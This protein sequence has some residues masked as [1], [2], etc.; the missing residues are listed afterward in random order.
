MKSIDIKKL[1]LVLFSSFVTFSLFAKEVVFVRSGSSGD[2]S[3]WNKALGS[4]Q[5]AVD[6]ASQKNADV[7][8]AKGVYKNDSVAVVS[9]KP[10]VNLYGGFAGNESSI[11][12]RDTAKNPTVL[13]GDQKMRVIFQEN[14]FAD[15]MAVIVDGFIIQNGTATDGGGA[16]LRK[17]AVVNNCIL[18]GNMASNRGSAIYAT[19]ATIKNS[20]IVGNTYLTNLSYTIQLY[21]CEMEG[22][23]VKNNMGYYHSAICAENNS[24]VSNCE[25]EN[26]QSYSGYKGSYFGS[27][28]VSNCRFIN[29]DGNGSSVD[30]RGST[31]M[32]SCLFKGNKNIGS[33]L[34]YVPDSN[35]L[36]EDCQIIDNS[37]ISTLSVLS[38]KFNRCILKGNTTSSRI[39][40]SQ[41]FSTCISNC[42][43]CNNVCTSSYEP[44]YCNNNVTISNC[45][46]VCNESNNAYF[47][48]LSGSTLKNSIVVGNKMNSQINNILNLRGSNTVVN[49]MLESTSIDGNLCGSMNYAAFTDVESGDFSLSANSYCINAGAEV[50]DTIDLLGKARI[51]GGVVDMG[52]IESSHTKTVAFK[53]GDIVYVKSG[54]NGDG[55]SWKSAFGDVQQAVFAASTDGKKHQI[56]V[57]AGT[58]Y[59]DTTLSSVVFLSD[60]ISMYGGFAGNET[61]LAAR[62][63]VKNPTVLDG[64]NKRRVITQSCDFADSTAIV[65]DGFI[66]QNGNAEYGGGAYL[67]KNAAVNNCILRNNTATYCGLAIYAYCAKIKNSI[68]CNNNSSEAH[69]TVHLNN[70]EMDSCVVKNNTALYTSAINADLSTVSNS[71]ID[72]NKN[73]YKSGGSPLYLNDQS[74][75]TNCIITN[76]YGRNGGVYAYNRCL[77]KNC[78]FSNNISTA[79]SVIHIESNSRI[80]DSKIFDNE[81]INYE[82]VYIYNN[83]S[84]NRC[85]VYNNVV[86]NNHN[87]VNILYSS[88]LYNSLIYGNENKKASYVPLRVAFNSKMINTTFADNVTGAQFALSL[89][90][91]TI[92]NSIVVGNRFVNS[93]KNYIE[94]NG[95]NSISYSMI[96]GGAV[97]EGNISGSKSMASF[98]DPENGDYSLSEKSYCIDRGIETNDSL[99]LLG[100]HRKLNGAVDL[101]AIESQY[102]KATTQSVGEIIYVKEGATGDGS[103]WKSAFGDVSEAIKVAELDGKKHQIWVASGTYYGDT[104]MSTVVRLTRDISLYGGFVG[105]ET[106][107]AARDTAKNPTVLDGMNKRRVITQNYDF[108]DS[109][110]IVV[111][112]FIIQNGYAENGGG[113]YVLKNTTVNNCIIKNC[114]AN[115]YGMAVYSNGAKVANSLICANGSMD[116]P[117]YDKNATLYLIGGLIDSCIVKDN[118]SYSIGVL[119][120]ESSIVTNSL[121]EGNE[122]ATSDVM[123]FSA[124]ILSDCKIINN[125]NSKYNDYFIFGR[126]YSK[127]DRC[128]ID[129][130]KSYGS[131]IFINGNSVLSNSQITNCKSIESNLIYINGNSKMLNC[132]VVDNESRYETIY[133]YSDTQILNSIIVGNKHTYAN[134]NIQ[135]N[136]GGVIKYCMIEGGAN[137]ERNIDGNKSSASFVDV[138]NGDYSLSKSSICIN[139]GTDISDTLD[140]LGNARKQN[141]AVD[142]GAIESSFSRKISIDSIIYVKAGANGS[143]LSWDDA[144]GEINQAIT[145][146]TTTGKR[147]KIWVAKGTYYGDTTS[148][149]A[150]SLA[151]GIDLYGGFEGSESSLDERNIAKNTTIIDGLAKRKCVTQNYDFADSLAIVVNGFTIQN[152]YT[153]DYSDG[154]NAKSLKN[155]SFINCVFRESKKSDKCVHAEKSKFISCTFIDNYNCD[156]YISNGE[157]DSCTF[158]K[159]HSG[160]GS[161][162]VELT[163]SRMTNS[164]IYDNDPEYGCLDVSSN[165]VVSNCRISN[166]KNV[167]SSTINMNNSVI[168]NSLIYDNV[169]NSSSV[170]YSYHNSYIT[171]STIAN[172]TTQNRSTVDLYNNSGSE[173]F[174]ITNTIIYGNKMTNEVK[175]QVAKSD[176]LKVMYCA[177]DDDLNGENNIKLAR[178]NNGSD[179]TLNYVCFIN[180]VGGDYR[181]HSTSSCIDKGLDSVM[182]LKTDI[183]GRTRIYGKAIDL[184]AIE[185]NGGSD[186]M[187]DYHQVVCY[188]KNTFEVKFDTT[189]STL[190]WNITNKGQVEGFDSTS[191]N[192]SCIPTMRLR[193]SKNIIDTLTLKVT[194]YDKDS[195]GGMPFSYN[196]YVYPDFSKNKVTFIQPNESYVVNKKSN[197]MTIQWKK[198][199]LPVE[200]SNYDLYVWKSTQEMPSTPMNSFVNTNSK[201]LSGLDNHTTYKYM[202]K[203]ATACDTVCSEIDSFRIDIPIG[204]EI[205][206]NVYCEFGSKLNE[207]SSLIRYV[208]GV[209]LTD[210]ITYVISGKDSADFSANFEQDWD[211]YNGGHLRIY[212]S[213]VDANKKNSDAK[214]TLKSGKYEA[215]L[216]L[217]GILSNYYVFDAVVD[218]DVY[219]AGDT[220]AIKGFVSD[221]YG[222]PMSGKALK[223]SLKKGGIE[224]KTFEEMSASN[225]VVNVNYISS[226]YE[227]GVYSVGLC[228]NSEKSDIVYDEFDIPG[229]SCSIGTDKWIVQKGDTVYGTVTVRNRSNVE[230]H[231]VKVRTLTLA[232]GCKVVFDSIDVLH[233]LESRELNYYVVGESLTNGD[234]L[235]LSSFRVQTAESLIAGFSTY[236]YCENPY[237]LIKVLPANIK[238][239][240]SK[241]KPKFVELLLCNTGLGETGKVSV[242][243]PKEFE[244]MTMLGGTEIES[245]KSGDTTKAILKLAYYDGAKLNTPITGSIGINCENGKSTTIGFS[246]EYTSSLVGSVSV[247]VVD[248]YYYNTTAKSHLS[249]ATVEI[250]NAFDSKVIASGISDSLGKVHFDSIPEGEYL[251]CIKADKHSNYREPISVQAGQNLNKFIFVS[252]QAVTYTWN[253]ERT[254]IEDK[255]EM[256]LNAEFET[257]VPAPVVT[258]EF[259]NGF[260]ERESF[261]PGDKKIAHLV[262][263]NHGLIAAKNVKINAPKTNGYIFIPDIDH[264]DSLPANYSVVVPV[265]IER[266]NTDGSF[267]LTR[268]FSGG[269]FSNGNSITDGNFVQGCLYWNIHYVYE[270]N[271]EE[272]KN[273]YVQVWRC[274]SDD[275]I[276]NIGDGGDGE[277]HVGNYGLV[278]RNCNDTCQVKIDGLW[279]CLFDLVG[280]IPA[281]GD[282]LEGTYVVSKGRKIGSVGNLIDY[283]R[284]YYGAS[285]ELFSTVDDAS[286]GISKRELNSH[287][288]S[289][290]TIGFGLIPVVGDIPFGCFDLLCQ[291]FSCWVNGKYAKNCAEYFYDRDSI[292]NAINGSL[293]S[294]TESV[295]F[296]KYASPYL[297]AVHDLLELT[298]FEVSRSRLIAEYV[299][300]D[301]VMMKK[302]GLKDYLDVFMD[303]IAFRK[304]ID[305]EKVKTL[306]ASD[307]SLTEM[308]EISER[309]NRTVDAW[310]DSVFVSDEKYP[311]IVD[312]SIVDNHLDII[313]NFYQYV[314]FRGFDDI[315]DMVDFINAEMS[316]KNKQRKSVCASVKLQISQTMTMTREAFDGTLT[317]NN[318][319]ESLDMD[320]FRVILEVRDENGNLANDLFQINT[321]SLKGID[322]VD[323]T[324]SIG[325]GNEA[326]AVFR[327]I[328]ERG[329]APTTPVNY[330]FGGK[331]IYLEAGDTITIDM[332]PVTLTVNPSPNLQI[333]YFMQRNILGD[334]ALT[335]DR[336]EPTVPAALGVRIDNHGYGIA[337][338]VK[339]ETAQPEIVENEKGLLID[340]SIIGSSLDGKNYDL[341]SENIDFGNIEAHTAKTGVWW[342]T[343]SLLGHFTKYEA[344][345]VHANSFGNPEL[346]LVSGIA[347]HELIKTVD[348]YGVKEDHVTDFLVNDYEDGDD[349]PDAIYYS[350][351]GKDTVSVAKNTKL[352]KTIVTAADTV[353]KLTVSPSENGWNYAQMNDPG[354]NC[355]DIKRV[356]RVKDNVEIPLS[357][358][359]T[360]FVTLP[361]GEEPIYENRLHFLDYMTTLSETD[362]N[363]YFSQKK[364]LLMVTEIA[365]APSNEETVTSSIDSVIVKFN[366]KI[367]KNSFDYNDIELYCQA[368]NNLSDSTITVK[369]RDDYTYVVNISSKT[370]TS[371]FYKFEVN[372]DNVYDEL[373]Y[374]GEFG[375]NVLWGQLIDDY[376]SP[377]V[378]LDNDSIVVYTFQNSVY[379]KSSNAG[380]LDIYDILSRLIVKN[381]KYDEGVS[382]VAVLPRGIYIINGEKI[383]VK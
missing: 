90:N 129:G 356:V 13:D 45:T 309:W 373:G 331:I 172:N 332:T 310:S 169:T 32:T 241:Q 233:G 295:D 198:L 98:T 232:D 338:N 2:G 64:M 113:A 372:V 360:T 235:L 268:I 227:C 65:V 255:Y 131:I 74:K 140:L 185:Y 217:T 213:P 285:G 286:N 93:F 50:N 161:K 266:A 138:A 148:T 353:V 315:P 343:S 333:D 269:E 3:S 289:A 220:I 72:N 68:I 24:K 43:V 20:Q 329:A 312:K 351:G 194:P 63:T 37:A 369:Q 106:S 313:S 178:A 4:I 304:K 173:Y 366:R 267:T 1:L 284:A 107:L 205:S 281:V 86:D 316:N 156:I 240:V 322:A 323:G 221:A 125:V 325:S 176:Y 14:D 264:I 112:G 358:V 101:G 380:E 193:T 246:M 374:P 228:M 47:I 8:V 256:T 141:E 52:A 359:W 273:F 344:S 336:V 30:L 362:Y 26:N 305:I 216:S 272:H 142:M 219:K 290:G 182:T 145:L 40:E 378:N 212:Y 97:G 162:S 296:Y 35:V 103:S 202:V 324:S 242:S 238:E 29:T 105:N 345:V 347:I 25:F 250:K 314:V 206:G 58:Y 132:T 179:T 83:S 39:I 66:I 259:P 265:T 311:N 226:L 166:N 239:Y 170:I 5:Q 371:G 350:N 60:R 215:S 154:A 275:Y 175:P 201:Y 139:A 51:Q 117:N 99:D 354:N 278:T 368:G 349:T 134:D 245:I 346:S 270:C 73:L 252:Y 361:D 186:K 70:S 77:V 143:G 218:K 36:V 67:R 147:H 318:G 127:I 149:Y 124:T 167:Y 163:G 89:Q 165:S 254:E 383:I 260:P 340:F 342:L 381:A 88:T 123:Y 199:T 92:L 10:N 33:N 257:N 15:S 84:M 298:K 203:A 19:N 87:I 114:H 208:K 263:T 209:E 22:C 184:G 288:Y 164:S 150:I 7:W 357:N 44:I 196:Y 321:H 6:L 319:Q 102:K 352:D 337:K 17:N 171:N 34:L 258:A 108:P 231:N 75:L 189:I 277:F 80:E 224:I 192:G 327:F 42:L 55:S 234:K 251:L 126:S 370:K 307:L 195:V 160:N 100:N 146:A 299:G 46:V 355:Y 59:G 335:I 279:D 364:N 274:I 244:G 197:N 237:G 27:T 210:S 262:I 243:L 104:T 188:N 38:G 23:V 294:A 91:S 293:R 110:A 253:V 133:S 144:L 261:E 211:K 118:R 54:S 248:E 159:N 229:I 271:E 328:P 297:L 326:S 317:V 190:D 16:Y 247:D 177:S 18:K 31:V 187:L 115:N 11:A 62:D 130:N 292:N 69:R 363:I 376:F 302:S 128:L 111:D 122:S 95:T 135:I 82:I 181:L 348:A 119:Q 365:G 174:T 120:A 81:G 200:I 306:P 94:L 223:L 49:N 308:I 287:L 153:R 109:S 330:S 136:E 249:G 155:T 12:V 225:G 339:L 280:L 28:N 152:G 214:I 204:I 230:S 158:T 341:G 276:L 85:E 283:S 191:G 151:A 377:V 48:N 137:G 301:D 121:F 183:N 21:H 320:S 71:I 168:E 222:N 41:S 375:K 282:F 9:L 379:V 207:T 303:S 61:S 291:A 180:A 116:N 236:F 334:D 56:W 367:Q 300:A 53:C 382:K 78:S 157:I 57:A 96:E 79:N 76:N